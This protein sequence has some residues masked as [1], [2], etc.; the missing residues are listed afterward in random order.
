MYQR[1]GAVKTKNKIKLAAAFVLAVGMLVIF[2]FSL[3]K[4]IELASQAEMKNACEKIVGESIS[5]ATAK[6]PELCNVLETQK[7]DSGMITM[8][9]VNSVILNDMSTKLTQ[10][11]QKRL[12]E[13]ETSPL[14]FPAGN[15]FLARLFSGKGPE[16]KINVYPNPS[17]TVE[18]SSDFIHTGINQ[19][20]FTLYVTADIDIKIRVGLFTYSMNISRKAAVCNIIIVGKVPQTYANLMQGGDFLNLVP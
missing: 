13:M 20:M 17:G 11:I 4:S 10:C 9:S 7:D 14:S 1:G 19:S 6:T 8:V 16:I 12:N 18:Y 5:E 2:S 3:D 15:V